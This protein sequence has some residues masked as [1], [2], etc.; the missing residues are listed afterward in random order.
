MKSPVPPPERTIPTYHELVR[1]WQS[2]RT[3]AEQLEVLGWEAER[4]SVLLLRGK[5]ALEINLVEP[6]ADLG[7]EETLSA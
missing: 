6:H 2:A 4:R 7:E 5:L 1:A 3:L